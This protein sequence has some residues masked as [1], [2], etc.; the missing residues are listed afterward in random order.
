MPVDEHTVSIKMTSPAQRKTQ[1]AS[2]LRQYQTAVCRMLSFCNV[3]NDFNIDLSKKKTF[4]QLNYIEITISK[5]VPVLFK[6][7]QHIEFE[8]R[9][10]LSTGEIIMKHFSLDTAPSRQKRGKHF[11][12]EYTSYS[13]WG[14]CSIRYEKLF[15]SYWQHDI[16]KNCAVGCGPVAWAMVFGYYD[17]RSHA[18]PSNFGTGSQYLYRSGSDG[19]TGSKKC[20]APK[21][22]D[23]SRIK[24]YIE[25]MARILGTWCINEQGATPAYKMDHIKGFFK[26]FNFFTLLI[27]CDIY[28]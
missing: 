27:Y 11:F 5:D 8:M 28:N 9:K 12:K 20:E 18:K 3:I 17:R 10:E 19:T 1:T 25:R 24:K 16:R 13:S 22:S 4:L 21:Y 26:V 14:Y 23:D 6:R 15:P 7:T 2:D